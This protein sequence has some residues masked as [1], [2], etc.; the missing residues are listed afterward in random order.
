L[1]GAVLLVASGLLV[2]AAERDI[3]WFDAHPQERAQTLRRCH[4]DYRLA[5]TVECLNAEASGTRDMGRMYQP[6]KPPPPTKKR[7]DA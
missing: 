2:Q 4:S 5:D 7:P 6:I 1:I 3:D